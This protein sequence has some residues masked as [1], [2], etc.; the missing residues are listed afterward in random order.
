MATGVGPSSSLF[1]ASA[2]GGM[3]SVPVYRHVSETEYNRFIALWEIGTYDGSGE[4]VVAD[5]P[6]LAAIVDGAGD[7]KEEELGEW[8]GTRNTI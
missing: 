5:Q 8:D 1:D 6:S 3:T 7:T 4:I 2:L